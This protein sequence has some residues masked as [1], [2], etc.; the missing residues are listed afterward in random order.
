MNLSATNKALLQL[1]A[2]LAVLA[3]AGVL[4]TVTTTLSGTEVYGIITVIAGGTAVAGG[5]ALSATPANMLPHL[6]L[7]AGV[8]GLTIALAV[9]KVFTSTDVV[10]VFG[11]ILGGGALGAGSNI[12]A[13]KVAAMQHAQQFALPPAV[14]PPP[15]VPRLGDSL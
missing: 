1:A 7:I 10:G 2:V 15:P 14:D 11:F 6:L 8:L 3:A 4:A 12:V 13:T 9:E 5:L